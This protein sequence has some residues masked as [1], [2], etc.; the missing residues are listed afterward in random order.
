[1]QTTGDP[2]PGGR[3]VAVTLDPRN[4]NVAIAATHSG[5]LFRTTDGA[6]SWHHVDTLE[7]NRFWDV[8]IQP[9][10]P[11]VVIATVLVDTHAPSQSG[12]WRSTDGGLNW[13]RPV[14][15]NFP[16]CN[17]L[18]AYGRWIS[19]GPG[20]HI[21]VATDCGL[22]VS[23][24]AG[25]S[26][27]RVVPNVNS[28]RV[29]GVFSRPGPGFA[30][31]SNDVIVDVCGDTAPQR[32]ADAGTT[33]AAGTATNSFPLAWCF[34][35]GS[36]DET[37]V[38]FAAQTV[39]GNGILWESD[40][41]GATWTILKQQNNPGRF[42]WVRTT[43]TAS[44]PKPKFDLFFHM[45]ADVLHFS[46]DSSRVSTR[47]DPTSGAPTPTPVHDYGGMA[48][49]TNG[50]PRYMGQDHGVISSSD[51]GA[52]WT[53]KHNGLRALQIYDMAGTILP[54]HVDLYLSTQDNFVWGSGD[55]GLTWPGIA[56]AEGQFLQAP[57]TATQHS[58][59]TVAATLCQPCS[60]SAW[61]AHLIG[62][63]PWPP[64][65]D[66]AAPAGNVNPPFIIPGSSGPSRFVEVEN[67]NLWVR[68]TN[69]HWTQ[70]SPALPQLAAPAGTPPK[71]FVA[72]PPDNPTIYA[73]TQRQDGSQTHG[74]IRITG[75]DQPTLTVTDVSSTLGDVYIW[76][77][78][79]NPHTFPFAVGV[80]PQDGNFL[81]VGDRLPGVIRVST[82]GGATWRDDN[83]LTDLVTD[84]G[85]LQFHAPFHGL[86]A[87]VIKYNPSNGFH[88]LV[89]TEA[90]GVIETCDG[91]MS[92][93]RMN[94]SLAAKAVSDF[95][96][97]EANQRVY[98]ATYGRSLWQYDYPRI[99]KIK[100]PCWRPPTITVPPRGVTLSISVSTSPRGDPALVDIDVDSVR[101]VSAAPDGFSTGPRPA[102]TGTHQVQ[103]TLSPGQPNP[104]VYTM[105][106]GGSCQANGTITLAQGQNSTCQITVA[107]H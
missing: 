14:D 100:D 25:A 40:D 91:G 4:D 96:F 33:F 32:S 47:C 79:D 38:V 19:A 7:P 83:P 28:P 58:D 22:A 54:D 8:Q 103:A 102:S 64:P 59:V 72:G 57:H 73:V 94:G 17:N 89:G 81:M 9:N 99:A 5:G 27:S 95:F 51:C 69:G 23:H 1:M 50:C 66:Q 53:F 88:V 87:H 60:R 44:T 49:S 105:L 71:L 65:T 63:G 61:S 13:T 12:I 104:S 34:M 84:H 41:G 21:F 82:D 55:G 35:S 26:W 15:A 77:P 36:P 70:K 42:A 107:H 106:Y 18:P 24:D 97:D 10:A 46:C 48:F 29:S 75:I 30:T 31:N 45:G 2:F 80:A 90:S 76:A 43:R 20:Q 68:D 78:D 16:D 56:G 52:T 101:W 62:Q 67:S 92:W 37:D 3:V 98:V 11:D 86:Q 85:R 93:H 6:A 74:L 39:F